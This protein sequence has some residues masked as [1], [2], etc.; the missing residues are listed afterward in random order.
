MPPQRR[1]KLHEQAAAP[2]IEYFSVS[3]RL[4]SVDASSGAMEPLWDKVHELFT[5]LSLV[6]WRPVETVLV[7]AMGWYPHPPPCPL[8]VDP[9]PSSSSSW[10][11]AC[12]W[13]RWTWAAPT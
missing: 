8:P 7:F 9:A 3:E 5:S 11:R 2:F 12:V 6:A 10:Q 13:G 4:V 1:F